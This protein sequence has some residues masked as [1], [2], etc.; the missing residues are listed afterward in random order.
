MT[1]MGEGGARP[2]I[3]NRA[4]YGEVMWST[5]GRKGSNRFDFFDDYA[6]KRQFSRYRHFNSDL[7]CNRHE[8]TAF[9]GPKFDRKEFKH[10][11]EFMNNGGVRD[12]YCLN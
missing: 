12:E 10:P 7:D 9:R 5:Y 1:K 2:Y 8:N 3:S 4:S 6:P 11:V